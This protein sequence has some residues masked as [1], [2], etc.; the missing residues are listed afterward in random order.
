M[1][2]GITTAGDDESTLLLGLYEQGQRAIDGDDERFGFFVWEGLT[3]E[4]TE[5][6]VIRA[7]PAVA[8]GRIPLASVM[9]ESERM[10]SRPA[11]RA[12]VIRYTLNRFVEGTED[13]WVSSSIFNALAGEAMTG[14][15]HDVVYG[16]DRTLD[17]SH[18][19][20]TAG[21]RRDG[22]LVAEYVATIENP[23]HA[24]LLDVCRR[25]A[26]RGPCTFVM[27]SDT[28]RE[29]GRDLKDLGHR[30]YV[31]GSTEVETACSQAAAVVVR[32]QLVHDGHP[33]MR[34][35]SARAKRRTSRT[36]DGWRISRSL[37]PG[38]VDAVLSLVFV[39]FVLQIQQE[40]S[41]DLV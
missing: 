35:Q 40:T 10:W 11:S 39:L 24:A 38:D 12:K 25:L 19:S 16:L 34:Q 30:T 9:A 5:E 4:L 17:W 1:L 32:R 7:N 13:A 27:P 28:L 6:N 33:T 36:G 14:A 41:I 20:I 15:E 2:V 29:L 18:A 23:D 3:D 21:V 26:T 8:C 37:S 31:L 22:H